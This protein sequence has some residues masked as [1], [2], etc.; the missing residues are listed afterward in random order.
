MKQ[1]LETKPEVYIK[2]HHEEKETE[3]MTHDCYLY[4]IYPDIKHYRS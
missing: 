4:I 1:K 2:L 3:T